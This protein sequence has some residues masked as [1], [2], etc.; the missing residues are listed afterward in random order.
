MEFRQAINRRLVISRFVQ[1]DAAR[2]VVRA[3]QRDADCIG[4]DVVGVLA[5]V[6]VLYDIDSYRFRFVCVRDDKAA[7]C[8]LDRRSISGNIFLRHFVFDGCAVCFAEQAF[9]SISPV[10]FFVQLCGVFR[11]VRARERHSDRIGANT[12]LILCIIPDLRDL[13]GLFAYFMGVG[14]SEAVPG[15]CCLNVCLVS[16][17]RCFCQAVGDEFFVMIL[18]Q[19]CEDSGVP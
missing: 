13:N 12:V 10:V 18:R 17:N 15:F 5:V 2:G 3:G 6:P 11:V 19:A 9:K 4:T 14:D 8:F 16:F 1:C 7:F